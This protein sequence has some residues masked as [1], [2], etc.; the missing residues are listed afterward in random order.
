ME[1]MRLH[2]GSV[3]IASNSPP[4]L[5]PFL[6]TSNVKQSSIL[7]RKPYFVA[8]RKTPGPDASTKQVKASA[9]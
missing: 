2:G 6:V 8:A 4:R 7:F 1:N 9:G 3:M 5:Q